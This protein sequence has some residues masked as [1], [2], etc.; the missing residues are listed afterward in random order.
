M[1]ADKKSAFLDVD[2]NEEKKNPF[3]ITSSSA[4]AASSSS[5]TSSSSA[6]AP[7]S[8]PDFTMPVGAND[9]LKRLQAFLP[10]LEKANTSLAETISTKGADAVNIESINPNEKRVIEMDLSLGV[11]ERKGADDD[12]KS[13][14]LIPSTGTLPRASLPPGAIQL[15]SDSDDTSSDESDDDMETDTAA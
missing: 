2:A 8:K 12:E 3:L 10:E 11:L 15:L 5:T 4:T 14:I 13:S 7:R 6:A 9:T 1:A